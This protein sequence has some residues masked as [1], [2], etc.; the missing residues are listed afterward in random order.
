MS[1]NFVRIVFTPCNIHWIIFIDLIVMLFTYISSGSFTISFSEY[2]FTLLLVCGHTL[3]DDISIIAISGRHWIL[4]L[5]RTRGSVIKF[6][7]AVFIVRTIE[8]KAAVN[9]RCRYFTRSSTVTSLF[10]SF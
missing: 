9:V 2:E 10:G 1:I 5:L 7:E 6:Y 3:A 8:V 4:I